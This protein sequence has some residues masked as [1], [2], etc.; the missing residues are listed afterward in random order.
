[1]LNADGV[2]LGVWLNIVVVG[3]CVAPKVEV[4]VFWR[5]S[6]TGVVFWGVS[7]TEV[8]GFAGVV[9]STDVALLV[10]AP[11]MD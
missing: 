8:E 4:V 11:K 6:K 9:P 5:M 10:S 3:F 1:M 7:N 2:K